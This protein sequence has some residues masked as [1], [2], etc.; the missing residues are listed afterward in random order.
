LCAQLACAP[1]AAAAAVGTPITATGGQQLAY[2]DKIAIL[3]AIDSGDSARL[4]QYIQIITSSQPAGNNLGYVLN[5]PDQAGNTPLIRAGM[6]NNLE[7]T[8]ILLANGADINAVNSAGQSA[9]V[10]SYNYGNPDIAQY[11]IAQG[12]ADPYQIAALL[13][14]PAASTTAATATGAAATGSSWTALHLGT[15][16]LLA[17]GAVA[18]AAIAIDNGGSDSS[19][20]PPATVDN[21]SDAGIH[22]QN[23]PLSNYTTAEAT[24]QQG[25]GA[26]NTSYALARGYDGSIYNRNSNGTLASTTPVGFV[27]VAVMD[28]GVDLTHPDLA[29]NLATGSVTCSNTGC[30][31]G[32]SNTNSHGTR[33]AGI[34]AARQDGVGIYG[35]APQA[36][37]IS[38]RVT[39]NNGTFT[40]NFT[41]GDVA[42]I[43]Y[44][45]A[46]GVQVINS[47][48]GTNL[49]INSFTPTQIRDDLDVVVNGTTARTQ[50]QNM[51]ANKV[52]NVFSAGNNGGV[53]PSL[54]AA[55]PYYFQGATAPAGLSQAN[56][57]LVNPGRLDWSKH[58]IAA[59][60]LDANN[61]I[62]SFSQACGVAKN[63]CLAAPGEISNSTTPGGGYSGP[64]QGTSFSAPNITGAVA[65]ML[66]AF[67]HLAPE[68]VTQILFDTATDLG[69]PG[70]DDVY[71][72]GLVNLQKATSPSDGGWTLAT[73]ST[74]FAFESSGFALSAPFGNAL[75]SSDASLQF[76]DKYGKNYSIGLTSMGNTLAHSIPV[77][78]RLM[79]RDQRQDFD[80]LT[81]LSDTMTLGLAAE[82]V[83]NENPNI[84]ARTIPKISLTSA[85]TSD[86]G[87]EAS[88]SVNSNTSLAYAL[89]PHAQK[90]LPDEALKNPY[91]NL[92]NQST[93]SI[94]SVA[95]AD[96]SLTVAAYQGKFNSDE[97]GYRF[98]TEKPL[99]GAY[100]EVSYRGIKGARLAVNG[101]MNQ[102]ENSLL[103]SETSGAF[104]ID[105]A[106]TYHMGTS[107]Q[108]DI[109][110]RA[111]LFVNYNIGLT[112]V[113]ASQSSIFSAF[114]DLTT[115]A[116]ALG[117]NMNDTLDRGDRLGLVF[118]QPLRVMRGDAALTLPT[119]VASDGAMLY[120]NNRLNL[121]PS[122]TEYNIGLYYNLPL[123]GRSSINF[124]SLLRMN[125]QHTATD[126]DA[127]FFAKYMLEF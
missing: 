113:Q 105:R 5:F 20:T 19:S 35:V 81:P 27:K 71:G 14:Q 70:I 104:S 65:V 25:H 61:Q 103:G 1:Y 88:V 68:T 55:L 112:K 97:Y 51:V 96:T 66:G 125:P 124:D 82:L 100:A 40:G 33:V 45:V 118:S 31:S 38:I 46:N 57:D 99:H 95:S 30:V 110:D 98:E 101:G 22:P 107:T 75:A 17:G 94:A 21:V 63:W 67:P 23:E 92:I 41:R 28:S 111:G 44:A 53:Q 4:Q 109:G 34:I 84:P 78:D 83:P 13:A 119:G 37:F 79:N 60:S 32:G 29:P 106:L 8:K 115:S 62:S 49:S 15:A 9:L 47:S 42:G 121:A 91:L 120:Q 116:F 122:A 48:F 7:T 73:G 12:A 3:N 89:L 24:G 126:S 123:D 87:L 117:G 72:H 50:Y 102:E 26:M 74:S 56:Y 114:S 52:I 16:A 36:K 80:Q 69:A 64:I 18:G 76:L 11:L 6:T 86:P 93:S 90:S 59:I 39:E 127:T 2:S 54:P 43:Q 108:Y 58:W 10:T 85:L 77:S